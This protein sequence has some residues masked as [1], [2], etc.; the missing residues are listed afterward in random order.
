MSFLGR[1][2]PSC[3]LVGSE[4]RFLTCSYVYTGGKYWGRSGWDVDET[5]EQ[6][7][8]GSGGWDLNKVGGMQVRWVRGGRSGRDAGEEGRTLG[9]QTGSGGGRWEVG[10]A[11][12][13]SRT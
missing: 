1:S 10:E 9:R 11:G 3:S 6:V 13:E 12:E 2:R 5:D 4:N 7:G 8:H